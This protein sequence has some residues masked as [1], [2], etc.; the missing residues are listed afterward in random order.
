MRKLFSVALAVFGM[1]SSALDPEGPMTRYFPRCR[2]LGLAVAFLT[3]MISGPAL[4]VPT[5]AI[6]DF[7]QMDGLVPT[8]PKSG[9]S[10]AI[11]AKPPHTDTH[12]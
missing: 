4:A 9:R 11:H 12:P 10:W 1:G 6:A 2:R 5:V 3:A 8:I 7:T